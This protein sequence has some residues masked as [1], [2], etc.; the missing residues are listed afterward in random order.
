M[1]D[2]MAHD[3][4]MGGMFFCYSM[5]GVYLFTPRRCRFLASSIR[6]AFRVRTMYRGDTEN[7]WV[8]YYRVSILPPRP[9]RTI[10]APWFNGKSS[11][12][13]IGITRMA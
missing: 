2:S 7:H 9:G 12:E 6:E 1:L 3:R 11:L 5:I 10:P 13:N 4:A 8:M